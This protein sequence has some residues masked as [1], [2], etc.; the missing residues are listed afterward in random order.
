MKITH[1]VPQGFILVP[2]L[3]NIDMLPRA[4]IMENNKK[5]YHN[6]ADDAQIYIT[7]SPVD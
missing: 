1:G 3:F 4:S 6:Y 7:I 5:C 2:L